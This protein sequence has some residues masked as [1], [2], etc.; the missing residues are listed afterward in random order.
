MSQ[1]GIAKFYKDVDVAEA[2]DAFVVRLDGKPIKTP[3]RAVLAVPKRALA[4]AITKEWRDQAQIVDPATMPLTRLAYAAIDIASAHRARL[5]DEILAFGRTDL[6]CYR[7]ETPAALVARQAQ[8]WDS[9]LDWAGERFG[10][11]LATGTG[12]AFVEQP[13]ESAAAFAAAVRPCRNLSHSSA[14][15]ARGRCWAR[16]CWHWRS[17]TPGSTPPTRTRCPASTRPFRR[18][19]GAAMPRPKPAR[20]GS[21]ANCRRSSAS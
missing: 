11:G 6:L 18:K 8:G 20:P 21:P 14:S 16:W 12:I 5:V 9:L 10:A 17:S 2:G 15:M 4:E 19:P 7:A 3:H 13:P 1:R